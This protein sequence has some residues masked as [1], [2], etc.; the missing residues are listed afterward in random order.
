MPKTFLPTDPLL[1]QQWH[2]YDIGRLGYGTQ[3][4]IDGLSRIW[5]DYTGAGV[6]VGVWD[7][8]VEKTHWDLNDNYNAARQLTILGTLNNGQP[9]SAT[10]S[11]GTAVAGLIA[12]EN[13]GLGGVGVAFDAEV[14]GVTIFG[15]ADD[16]NLHWARYLKTLDSLS[17]FDIT[18]HSYGATPD[19]TTYGDAAKFEASLVAGRG[20]LGTINVKAAGNNNID[21]NGD[22]LDSSRST[23]TVGAVDTR[24]QVTYYS[25]FG[26]HLLISAPAGSV[27]VD[28]AGAA[29]GY[30]GLL[31]GDY[32]NAFGGTSAATPITAGVV[33]L[34]LD[35]NAGLGWRDVQNILAFSAM[36]TGSLQTGNTAEENFAWQYNGSATWNGGGAHFS[37][38]YGYGLINAFAAAR[39][40]EVWDVF[41]PE[42][43]TSSNE[44]RVETGTITYNRAITDG[45]TRNYTFNVSQDIDLE[46]VALTL[47]LIHSDARDL[48]ITLVSPDGTVMSVFDGSAAT[49]DTADFGLSFTF[50]LEGYRG[51]SSAGDW[52]LIVH[53]VAGGGTGTLQSVGFTGYGSASTADTVYHYTDEVLSTLNMAG[54][55]GRILLTDG[56]GGTDWIDAASMYRDLVINLSGGATSTLAGTAFLTIDAATIIENALGGDGNDSITGNDADNILGGMRGNDSLFG[57]DGI[58]TALFIG[59]RSGYIVVAADGTVTV[60]SIDGGYG[61]DVLIGFE[62]ARFDDVTLDLVRI[63]NDVDAPLLIDISPADGTTFVDPGANI[64]L[65][66]DEAVLAGSGAFIIYHQD[67]T[68]WAQIDATDTTQ[69]T[70]AEDK[71]TLNPTT[72]LDGLSEFYLVIEA[73]AVT[74]IAGNDFGGFGSA[75]DTAFTTDKFYNLIQGTGKSQKLGGTRQDDVIYGYN[76]NDTLYGRAGDDTLDGGA[77]RDKMLGGTGDDIYVVDNKYDV[78]TENAG[79][80]HDTVQ[81]ARA[82]WRLGANIEDLVFTGTGNFTGVGNAGRNQIVGG[83]GSDVLAGLGGADTLQ[84]GLGDDRLRGGTGLDFLTGG[85]GADHFV[86]A[87]ASEIGIGSRGDVIT[88]FETGI[89]VIDLSV[90][91]A[92]SGRNNQ[93]FSPTLVSAF[94]HQKGQLMVEQTL[95]GVVVS[96]DINGDG[97]ADFSLHVLGISLLQADDFIL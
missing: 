91:D 46:H 71:V 38:D 37:E 85:G 25:S 29:S 35:A 88:D 59:D 9:T 28:R 6:S 73:G 39:M 40:A 97:R 56:D 22:A 68:V 34:M 2:L 86:F 51:E 87:S 53:D 3:N 77:G 64:V 63:M 67:G 31:S 83:D 75:T 54:Q 27:T 66:F 20:G 10:A 32:T 74:D 57:G 80:G 30:N 93:A 17:D 36:G 11:H 47:N 78:I 13:N 12:G 45:S 43:A 79:A 19:Y 42:A 89:D 60:T 52:T 16:I 92:R 41:Q 14:T 94:T 5:A 50:G 48:R 58:D 18:N 62:F 72:F 69:V 61:I 7:D 76:G 81:T 49:A 55:S 65:T 95:D 96:G 4:S 24:G 21:G 1:A 70:F 84:G 44:Q 8:G 33:A 90:I 23:I 26:A 15:G 82:V